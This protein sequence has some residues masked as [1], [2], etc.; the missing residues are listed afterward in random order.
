VLTK[1][2]LTS[3][4]V[5]VLVGIA[6]VAGVAQSRGAKSPVVGVWRLSEV[7]ET[8]ANA[9]TITTPQPGLIIFTPRYYSIELVTSDAP[10]PELPQ[11]GATDKQR[12]DA[13]GPF[14]ANAGTYDIKG[15]ELMTTIMTAKNPNAMKSGSQTF[16][17]KMDGKNTLLLTQTRGLNGPVA[18]PA[19]VKFTRV[20]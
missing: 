1:R 19:T 15:N 2:L 17:F 14:T 8:G 12:A 6:Q 5:V 11:Q 16:T 4:I 3:A 7:T 10:R 18:N 20:E 9:R 13:F